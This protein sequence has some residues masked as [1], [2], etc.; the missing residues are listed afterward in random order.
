M[1]YNC[2]IK[3]SISYAKAQEHL[4]LKTEGKVP[5]QPINPG[6]NAGLMKAGEGVND[7]TVYIPPEER[8]GTQKGDPLQR[9]VDPVIP[10]EQ[11]IDPGDIPTFDLSTMIEPLRNKEPRN[12][13]NVLN[14]NGM[15]G[16]RLDIFEYRAKGKNRQAVEYYISPYYKM[17]KFN[18]RRD[19]IVTAMNK[20]FGGQQKALG[21]GEKRSFQA[22]HVVPI[23]AAF[24]GFHGIVKSYGS[25][26]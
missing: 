1:Q 10:P 4:R 18:P 9:K 19:A 6:T 26:W 8:I 14:Q 21:L 16:G 15:R 24:P 11:P 22:H 12:I 7:P 13:L 20:Q 25:T 5:T 3:S 23:K 2:H 17:I